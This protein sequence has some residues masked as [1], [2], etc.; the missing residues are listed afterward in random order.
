MALVNK[1]YVIVLDGPGAGTLLVALLLLV[2]TTDG[3][4]RCC[5]VVVVRL[6]AA[7]QPVADVE[8]HAEVAVELLVV[9]LVR[10]RVEDDAPVLQF[11]DESLMKISSEFCRLL[12][13]M[14]RVL[15]ICRNL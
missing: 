5:R 4:I 11:F 2:A 12:Q 14:P 7:A 9:L 3:V 1:Q 8:R 15:E 13:K 10:I 6:V